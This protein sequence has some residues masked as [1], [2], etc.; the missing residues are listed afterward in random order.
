MSLF[1][2]SQIGQASVATTTPGQQTP[3]GVALD[4]ATGQ[5][6]NASQFRTAMEDFAHQ[7]LNASGVLDDPATQ[8]LH[9]QELS[10]AQQHADGNDKGFFGS[11][12]NIVTHPGQVFTH[13]SGEVNSVGTDKYKSYKSLGGLLTQDEFNSF[14]DET[15]TWL[16]GHAEGTYD[17]HSTENSLKQLAQ[18]PGISQALAGLNEA[19]R[20]ATAAGIMADNVLQTAWHGNPTGVKHLFSGSGWGKAWQE[21]ND[22]SLGNTIV[23]ATLSPFYDEDSLAHMRKH[24]SLYQLSSFGSEIAATWAADPGVVAG[25]IGGASARFA[26]RQLPLDETSGTSIAAR[27]ALQGE[28][29]TVRNPVSKVAGKVVAHR[30]QGGW[31]DV[32]EYAKQS[33][34]VATFSGLSRGTPLPMFRNR[35]VDGIPMAQVIFTAAKDD[36]SMARALSTHVDELASKGMLPEGMESLGAGKPVLQ[37]LTERLAH[38][39]PKAYALLK[40]LKNE[41][42]EALRE[43]SPNAQTFLDAVDGL[44]T[45]TRQLEEESNRI[46]R[47]ID[48][49]RP[50][51][52]GY[53]QNRFD[54]LTQSTVNER[55]ADVAEA[56]TTLKA[57]DGYSSWLNTLDENP[58]TEGA[59]GATP[60]LSQARIPK[61]AWNGLPR[62]TAEAQDEAATHRFYGDNQFGF[63]HSVKR[64]PKAVATQRASIINFHD[65]DSG[66]VSFA[67]QH[68][69]FQ[70]LYGY[71]NPKALNQAIE[72]WN[73]AADP[74]QRFN[75]ASAYEESQTISAI[76]HRLNA[77]R[78]ANGREA[79]DFDDVRGIYQ[80]IIKKQNEVKRQIMMGQP[81]LMQTSDRSIYDAHT[82]GGTFERL[83]DRLQNE[84]STVQLVSQGDDYTTLALRDG[85]HLQHITVPNALL[86][87]KYLNEGSTPSMITQTANYYVPLDHRRFY[88]AIKRDDDFLDAVHAGLLRRGSA[89]AMRLIDQKLQTFNDLWK[90]WTLLRLGWPMRVL[91]DENARAMAILGLTT[92]I[93]KYGEA[94]GKAGINA[95]I[96]VAGGFAK[97]SKFAKSLGRKTPFDVSD[98]IGP[99]VVSTLVRQS[100]DAG[101]RDAELTMAPKIPESLVEPINSARLQTITDHAASWVDYQ[102][103]YQKA[104]AWE[105]EY[106]KDPNGVRI[107]GQRFGVEFGPDGKVAKPL[108][109]NNHPINIIANE[110]SHPRERYAHRGHIEQNQGTKIPRVYDPTNG[111]RINHGTIIELPNLRIPDGMLPHDWYTQNA[112]ILSKPGYRI[113]TTGRG[114]YG[115]ARWFQDAETNKARQYLTHVADNYPDARKFDLRTG[116][117]ETVEPY[118]SEPEPS[119]VET[120]LALEPGPI[121]EAQSTGQT[122]DLDTLDEQARRHFEFL[123]RRREIG[124]GTRNI[125]SSDGKKIPVPAAY[126]GAQGEMLFSEV[127]SA[128]PLNVVS[129]GH[130]RGLDWTR[131]AVVGHKVYQR[132]EFTEDALTPGTAANK[133]AVEYFGHYAD[134]VNNHIRFNPIMQRMMKGESDDQITD[135]LMGTPE[136]AR[137]RQ[138]MMPKSEIRDASDTALWVNENRYWLNHYVPNRALQRHLTKNQ[139]TPKDLREGVPD[140]RLPDVFGPEMEMI[141]NRTKYSQF[142]SKVFDKLW[143]GLGQVPIDQLS[144]HPFAKAHYDLKM[145]S[146]IKSTDSK[147]LDDATIARYRQIASKYAKN[148][149]KRFLWDLVDNTNFTD[150][151]RFIFPFWNAQQEALVKWGRIIMDRPETVARF[152]AGNRAVY[153]NFYVVN[154]QDQ[155][156]RFHTGDLPGAVSSLQS[157]FLSKLGYHPNDR[158]IVPIPSFLKK[159][160]GMGEALSTVGTVGVPLGSANTVLQGEMP[161]NPGFGPLVTMPADKFLRV[162][163]KDAGGVTHDHAFWYQWLFPVGRPQA[164]PVGAAALNPFA[165]GNYEN[166]LQQIMPGYAKR[167]QQMGDD[168]PG[169]ANTYMSV[170]RQ[171]MTYNAQHHLPPPTDSQIRK[172]A[173]WMWG[174][175]IFSGLVSPVQ[176]EFRPQNQMWIDTYRRYQDQY[177]Q[178]AFDHFLDDY[179]DV[180][181]PQVAATF[182]G[183]SSQAPYGTPPTSQGMKEFGKIRSLVAQYPQW[184]DA[185]FSQQAYDDQFNSDA[186]YIQNQIGLSDSNPSKLREFPGYDERMTDIQVQEG[187]YEYRKMN[188][189]ITAELQARGTNPNTGNPY[190]IT[191]KNSADLL[192]LKQA[193]KADLSQRN[194]AWRNDYNTDTDDADTR[195]FEA[196]YGKAG[197]PFGSGWAFDKTFDNRPDIQGFRQY[198]MVRSAA[199]AALDMNKV[200]GG[201]ADMQSTTDPTAI[202]VRNWFESQVASI[203]Q[204]NPA[205]AEFYSRYLDTDL[206]ES[207]SGGYGG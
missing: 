82:L 202:G 5:W 187:W 6:M 101:A 200:Q 170:G 168:G 25:K 78:V 144:H 201:T 127:G 116:V 176:T 174:L 123:T 51:Q 112:H 169:W 149:T 124:K 81:T 182:A 147:W 44:K 2:P 50:S 177:G 59:I 195:M 88:L 114:K 53:Q 145:Q 15:Q 75:V 166:V 179:G 151:A 80:Q 74:T 62:H 171:M 35:A 54:W 107:K 98:P 140:H 115:I 99:G 156:V 184:G 130:A 30:V 52:R 199:T 55:L 189:M 141:D 163:D 87:E 92:G 93:Q 90:P 22:R 4:M 122:F 132:P 41:S 40:S 38:G 16:V 100:T 66:P 117:H 58:V 104:A 12:V 89:D 173:M 43:Y 17:P 76:T 3:Y 94:W 102:R 84:A 26:T 71:A 197:Q 8:S 1:N 143:Y 48:Q 46:L 73:K 164:G 175:K 136:G 60:N 70:Q 36:G 134:V 131:K 39:D 72:D 21:S 111:K 32:W 150:A 159:I 155:A 191:D 85:Q 23:D 110:A 45:H 146:L 42:P 160:P 7:N 77:E 56:Q 106:A 120:G 69:Q 95:S 161:L 18:A 192:A 126:E 198:L 181:T 180:L 37:D 83:S 148:Q 135:W 79:L 13:L 154:D 158:M 97:A 121:G 86:D 10:A 65:L 153:Q 91:M 11:L 183:S 27:Q 178:D 207:G 133:A 129:E 24:S 194:P 190:K 204:Q 64:L 193:F 109:P 49:R 14:D 185:M 152:V 31:N 113:I 162:M 29:I 188:A 196:A 61:R 96:K 33:P 20:G 68:Q 125:R 205:F 9:D 118:R 105:R 203:V 139:I 108:S 142:F 19:Y 47:D 63:W 137:M 165:G 206:I 128:P 138:Q 172:Q 103:Q 119:P 57:Y 186:Y 157:K 167:I 28:K 67:R 34:D